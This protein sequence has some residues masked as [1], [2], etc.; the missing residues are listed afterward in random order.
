MQKNNFDIVALQE[1]NHWTEFGLKD[2][3]KAWGHDYTTFLETKT[4]YHMGIT[5][6]L[7]FE[8]IRLRTDGFWHGMIHIR[9]IPNNSTVPVDLLNPHY[10]N[11]KETFDDE[12]DD[13]EIDSFYNINPSL[14]PALHL[15]VTHLDP[16]NAT[17]RFEES[18][19]IDHQSREHSRLLV[20]GDL[21]ALSLYDAEHY[22][23]INLFDILYH[24]KDDLLKNK[25][26]YNPS[27]YSN[28][29][30]IDYRV[31][32]KFYSGKLFY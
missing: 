8:V 5:S 28:Q 3:A 22:N 23:E 27:T 7:P 20:L 25:F 9:M 26:L 19:H 24:S 12:N 2:K 4:G 32:E 18:H 11:A 17:S 1:L 29:Y 13:D 16:H 30:E 14:D 10:L 15:I 21:N 31:L 6:R